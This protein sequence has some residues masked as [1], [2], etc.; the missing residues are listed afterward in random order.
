MTLFLCCQIHFTKSKVTSVYNI[1]FRWLAR[2][3][4]Q[5]CFSILVNQL[6]SS[7][8]L[9]YR[10]PG[11]MDGF[12]Q[13]GIL[14]CNLARSFASC[15]RCIHESIH[16]IPASCRDDLFLCL[17]RWHLLPQVLDYRP[18]HSFVTSPFGSFP[19]LSLAVWFPV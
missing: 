2:M 5:G 3:Y 14:P 8:R 17:L 18:Q 7:F 19:S 13:G 11:A 9:G 16:I 6:K 10:N 1:P 4:T 15:N 12:H